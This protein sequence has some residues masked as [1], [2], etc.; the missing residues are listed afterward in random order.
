MA[1]NRLPSPKWP[2][3]P[4]VMSED[5]DNI[6]LYAPLLRRII[7][8]VAVVTAVPVVLWT[9]T[10]FMRTYVAPAKAPTFRSIAAATATP[11]P[12][13]A[14]AGTATAAP[15]A[16]IAPAGSVSQD[17][18]APKPS[19]ATVVA[20]ATTTD[21]SVSIAA[22]KGPLLSDHPNGG[23]ASAPTGSVNFAV[24]PPSAPIPSVP[25][26]VQS[27]SAQPAVTDS[28]PAPDAAASTGSNPAAQP[29]PASND[30]E[31]DA[32]PAADPIAGPIP[33]PHPRPRFLAMADSG[34]PMPRPRPVA[35]QSTDAAQ[36]TA[37]PL[38]WLGNIFHQN[39]QQQQQ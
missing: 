4:D 20:T 37:G 9:I 30:Q 14:A 18:G 28:G 26:S 12:V 32:L 15:A 3:R 34:I 39:Q 6:R 36:T 21:G 24:A 2:Q 16:T 5:D 11:A 35:A 10:A 7:I 8:L 38:D 23:D 13:G 31:A 19:S 27:P 22:P 25:D 17:A 33:L 29:Q 1:P